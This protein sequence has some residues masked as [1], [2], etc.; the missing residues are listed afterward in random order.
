MFDLY[1]F[2][3][4]DLCNVLIAAFRIYQEISLVRKE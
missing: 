3:T 1:I 2:L 4:G